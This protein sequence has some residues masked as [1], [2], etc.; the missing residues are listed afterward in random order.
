MQGVHLFFRSVPLHLSEVRAA[1]V[2]DAVSSTRRSG[3][4][5][6]T[7]PC[8]AAPTPK[9]LVIIDHLPA[10]VRL[11]VDRSRGRKTA[12]FYLYILVNFKQWCQERKCVERIQYLTQGQLIV[13]FVTGD[14]EKGC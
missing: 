2:V 13:S 12:D 7:R 14:M 6:H 5:G 3:G 1:G 11:G 8:S 9:V 10:R 4:L